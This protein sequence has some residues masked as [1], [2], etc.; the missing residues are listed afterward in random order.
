MKFS[1]LTTIFT[2]AM[3]LLVLAEE[4][5]RVGIIGLDTSHVVAFTKTM[6]DPKAKGHVPGAKVIAAYKGGSPD[7]ES[8]IS[9]VDGYTKTLQED[10]GVEIYDSIEELC[11]KVDAV[12]LESVDGRPHLAQARPVIAAKK[13][14][15]IDKP[16]VW[17]SS[18]KT[19][20]L[21]QSR[22]QICN[23]LGC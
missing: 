5:I 17:G 15:Y 10:Y 9:R 1:I 13:P 8:S 18:W 16:M 11:Q 12:M 7:I 4:P 23:L 20:K 19:Y 3:S 6:N 2:S 22:S 21:A 14:L